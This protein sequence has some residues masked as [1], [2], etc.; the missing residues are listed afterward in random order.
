MTDY[1]D[2]RS[3]FNQGVGVTFSPDTLNPR[4]VNFN[5]VSSLVN[6]KTVLD[7]GCNNGRWMSWLLDNGATHVTGIDTDANALT[8][9][10]SNLATYFTDSQYTLVE[11]SWENYTTSAAFDVV[12]CAGMIHLGSTQ[13]NL[14]NKLPSLG[15]T[16]IIE[17]GVT[18]SELTQVVT[19]SDTELTWYTQTQVR[20]MSD[21][22]SYLN[23]SS[24]TS[25]TWH[26]PTTVD[27]SYIGSILVSAS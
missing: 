25:I 16:A 2:N 7:I 19:D 23:S 11:S 8:A 10:R 18:S 13:S 5:A 9:A 27:S 15:T 3:A 26:S 21:I 17:G 4:A 1:F 20:T 24:Y 12:F 6:N 14:I 22:Q